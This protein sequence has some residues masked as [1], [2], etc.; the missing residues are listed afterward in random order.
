MPH[1]HTHTNETK[2]TMNR[3]HWPLRFCGS[4]RQVQCARN[5]V[6]E[7]VRSRLRSLPSVPAQNWRRRFNA[8]YMYRLYVRCFFVCGVNELICHSVHVRRS[9]IT[10]TYMYLFGNALFLP[11][12]WTITLVLS[13]RFHQTNLRVSN[14]TRVDVSE[15]W[16]CCGF[17]ICFHQSVWFSMIW[18]SNKKNCL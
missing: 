18:Y 10:Y 6:R 7:C 5:W 16:R 11:N 3:R 13:N 8:I 15:V 17:D 9:N 4:A 12:I 1:T 2:R 14:W